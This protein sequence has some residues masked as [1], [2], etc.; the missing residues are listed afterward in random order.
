MVLVDH[1][2]GC[3]QYLCGTCWPRGWLHPVFV[4]YLLATWLVASNICVVLV[5]HMVGYILYLYVT[6]VG[7]MVGNIQYLCVVLVGHMVGYIL[8]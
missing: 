2:V 1:M 5:G 4:W 8:Y 7:H 6:L 3:I